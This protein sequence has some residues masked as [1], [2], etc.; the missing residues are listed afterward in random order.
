MTGIARVYRYSREGKQLHARTHTHTRK[1]WYIQSERTKSREFSM[2]WEQKIQADSNEENIFG[3][4]CTERRGDS[5]VLNLIVGRRSGRIGAIDV[6]EIAV[7]DFRFG[8]SWEQRWL[9]FQFRPIVLRGEQE[10]KWVLAKH[11]SGDPKKVSTKN[12]TIFTWVRG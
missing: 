4:G 1:Q 10:K 12:S 7:G 8:F 9:T 11:S 5:G 3:L 6:C 2:S